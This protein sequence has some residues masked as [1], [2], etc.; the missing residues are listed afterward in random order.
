MTAPDESAER[1]AG[2]SALTLRQIIDTATPAGSL[3]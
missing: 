1:I 2:A 3:T